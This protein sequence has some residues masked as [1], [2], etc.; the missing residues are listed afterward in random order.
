M[1]APPG[2]IIARAPFS[3]PGTIENLFEPAAEPASRLRLYT[4]DRLQDFR[5][6]A[7]VERRDGERAEVRIDIVSKGVPP[8][9]AMLRVLPS[10]FMGCD[11]VLGRLTECH[12][13]GHGRRSFG[14]LP[15]LVRSSSASM[16]RYRACR[17][18]TAAIYS[19][20][21]VTR[22]PPVISPRTLR[23]NPAISFHTVCM[24]YAPVNLD[25]LLTF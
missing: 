25:A 16:S 22:E 20:R 19:N 18:R 14:L 12:G 9:L 7:R 8:L 2:R 15:D 1:P 3:D 21:F 13:V 5:H 17:S 11:I 24:R 10:R 6:V 23:Q 4:P